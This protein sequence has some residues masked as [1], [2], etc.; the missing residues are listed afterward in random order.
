MVQGKRPKPEDYMSKEDRVLARLEENDE[1][2]AI[3]RKIAGLIK[4]IGSTPTPRQIKI[5]L[6]IDA[7]QMRNACGDIKADTY[8]FFIR[9]A[10]CI[11]LKE[12]G[13]I[14]GFGR[15]ERAPEEKDN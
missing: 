15:M 13:L 11:L 3:A 9:E 7:R 1:F 5:H 12:E 2:M 4:E 10:R 8:N 14:V 6:D